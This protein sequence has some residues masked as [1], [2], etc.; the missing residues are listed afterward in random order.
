MLLCSS[1]GS[2]GCA[3][4]GLF[5]T[6]LG[7]AE[8]GVQ[9]KEEPWVWNCEQKG[10]AV[11]SP[12]LC[13]CDRAPRAAGCCASGAS[14]RRVLGHSGV[15]PT[16]E[17][18]ALLQVVSMHSHAL[19]GSQLSPFPRPLQPQDSLFRAQGQC[20]STALCPRAW[21]CMVLCCAL[22]LC[23]HPEFPL[24]KGLPAAVHTHFCISTASSPW[25]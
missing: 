22:S 3:R 23:K 21:P 6:S 10:A 14:P 16:M 13:V 5:S 8:R 12:L 9:P 15:I 2:H 11:Q 17:G 24:L 19:P 18:P 7:G 4:C 25:F 1:V 20:S